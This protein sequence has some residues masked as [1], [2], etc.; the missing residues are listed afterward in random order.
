MS[1]Q[2][3][4]QSMKICRINR[5]TH[6]AITDV[7]YGK[8]HRTVHKSVSVRCAII[9]YVIKKENHFSFPLYQQNV[10]LDL[11]TDRISALHKM[12]TDCRL[13]TDQ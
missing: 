13:I 8:L 6:Y 10:F 11:Q 3:Y 2:N 1:K 12:S 7:D 4:K 9:Q 5:T